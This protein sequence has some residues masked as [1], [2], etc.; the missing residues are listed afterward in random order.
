MNLKN[1]RLYYL[2][3]TIIFLIYIILIS[4]YYPKE[5][6]LNMDQSTFPMIIFQTWKSKTE[7]PDN[8]AYWRK[9]WLNNHP[10]FEYVLMDDGDNRSFIKEKF[11][12]FLKTFDSY[13]KNVERADAIRYFFLYVNGGI[14]ADM[15]FESLKPIGGLLQKYSSYDVLFGSME[16]NGDDFHTDNNIPN[17]I[18]ISKP[19]QRFW[20]YVFQELLTAAEAGGT[21]EQTTGPV[22]LKR[23][24]EKYADK[25]AENTA[26]FK[27]MLA[28]LGEDL[29]PLETR[30]KIYVF[31]PNVLYPLSWSTDSDSRES[32][33]NQN[34]FAALTAA[35]KKKHPESYAITYWTHNW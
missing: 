26:W 22:V 35:M 3:C 10:D 29:Q 9:T 13:K 21:T 18:M 23:A 2:I 12:W 33:L 32:A 28:T 8:Y 30:T 20:L 4:N 16:S 6:F 34:D 14:Y 17:A 25:P 11:P 5:G 19:R 1:W 24:I 7:F 27:K 15:D 31:E